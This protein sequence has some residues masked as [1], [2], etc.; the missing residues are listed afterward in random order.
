MK[1]RPVFL[2]TVLLLVSS[3]ASFA[4]AQA[5]VTPDTLH[6]H[7]QSATLESDDEQKARGWRLRI[8]EWSRYQELMK[9]PLGIHS[10]N[11]D[12]LTAL[13][14]EARTEE[15]RR[16]YAELQVQVEAR[17]VEKLLAYQLAY[18]AAWKRLYPTLQPVS[19]TDTNTNILTPDDPDRLAVFVRDNCPTCEQRVRQ[20]QAIGTPFD[21]YMVDSQSDDTL[22]R[23]WAKQVN[24][25]PAKVRSHVITLNHD[26][27]HWLSLG[28]PGE[29]PAV[30][31]K[32]NGQWQR[33]P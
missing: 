12:P 27:G 10:P 13:G 31:R 11:L 28:L 33:Q 5:I 24:I 22:I 4:I 30:L 32:V 1:Q 15:E 7:E 25:D 21:L 23:T 20:L 6:S 29:L 9:G 16:R 26:T 17:R 14:I 18:D 2:F 8:D 3:S 19:L